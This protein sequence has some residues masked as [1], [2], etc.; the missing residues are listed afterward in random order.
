MFDVA[1]FDPFL[2]CGDDLVDVVWTRVLKVQNFL[3][4]MS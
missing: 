3:D 4:L 1:F 2:C